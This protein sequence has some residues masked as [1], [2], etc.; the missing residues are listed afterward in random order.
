MIYTVAHVN[1]ADAV[2]AFGFGYMKSTV[3]GKRKLMVDVNDAV[4]HIQVVNCKADKLADA[5]PGAKQDIVGIVLFTENWVIPYKI[6]ERN[7]ICCSSVS[8][9]APNL[10]SAAYSLALILK[11]FLRIRSS[12]QA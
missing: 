8:A 9:T 5:E 3:A 7:E 1:V 11:G 2:P 12:S 6:K 4:L 10:S